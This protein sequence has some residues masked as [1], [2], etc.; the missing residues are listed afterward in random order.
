MYVDS[1]G[2]DSLQLN[3]LPRSVPQ[4]P[5]ALSCDHRDMDQNPFGSIRI[6]L[7]LKYL[8]DMKACYRRE[9]LGEWT[10]ATAVCEKTLRETDLGIKY[11]THIIKFM[12]DSTDIGLAI[13]TRT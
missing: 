3:S 9:Q 13:K 4:L 7:K 2:D 10:T 8:A 1:N 12:A 11:P 6:I 5:T